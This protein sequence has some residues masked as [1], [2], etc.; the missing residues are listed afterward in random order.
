MEV[1]NQNI[2]T[3]YRELPEF[4]D[5]GI[6]SFTREWDGAEDHPKK[7]TITMDCLV[8]KEEINEEA[9]C[10]LKFYKTHLYAQ[11]HEA[12]LT[13]FIGEEAEIW[14]IDIINY[15][16]YFQ[17]VCRCLFINDTRDIVLYF[18]FE[19][20]EFQF[21]PPKDIPLVKGKINGF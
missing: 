8:W 2:I 17:K 11:S 4:H 16:V 10:Q 13:E 14:T 9:L 12:D 5:Q 18:T 19:S 3:D 1:N 6:V 7:Y 20:M 21:L 15:P